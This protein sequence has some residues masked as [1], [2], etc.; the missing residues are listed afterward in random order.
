LINFFFIFTVSILY[1]RLIFNS[2][3]FIINRFYFK[4]NW[5]WRISRISTTIR[6]KFN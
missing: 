5:K 2:I 4:R 1:F 6:E 3:L